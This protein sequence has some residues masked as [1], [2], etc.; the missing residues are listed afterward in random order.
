MKKEKFTLPSGKE[1]ERVYLKGTKVTVKVLSLGATVEDITYE[2]GNGDR[3]LV[4]GY[5]DKSLYETNPYYFGACVARVG[6]RIGGARFTLNGKTYDLEKNDGNNNLHSGKDCL[7][8][9]DWKISTVTDNSVT[10]E[11]E[12]PDGDMGFPGEMHLCVTYTVTED[13]ALIIDYEGKSDV[14]TL[15]NPTNHSYFNLGED[16]TIL[17]GM[18][19][20]DAECF[21]PGGKES[22][23]DGDICS[24][25]GT[26]MD[27]R[28]SCKIGYRIDADFEELKYT[29]G[30]DHN[31]VLSHKDVCKR[32]SQENMDVFFAAE[33][34]DDKTGRN[35]EVYTS[36]PGLQVYTGNFLKGDVT[37][38]KGEKIPHRGGVCLETQ[39]FPN[40][41]NVPRF[42]QPV[43]KGGETAKSRTVYRFS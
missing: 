40:A 4:L 5:E 26:P 35:M 19:K 31:Y 24:V 9:R 29:G 8:F 33:L 21:T 1:V 10:F 3:H 28:A 41:I 36:L 16:T 30:Y 39:Y 17:S 22:I 2:E 18:L 11:I 25:S 23:P 32:Y 34:H 15:F 12:S 20:V 38:L 7:C 6:N 42:A 14:D 27:F 13:D 37:G 43:I